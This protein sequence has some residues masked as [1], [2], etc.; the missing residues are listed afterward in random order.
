MGVCIDLISVGTGYTDS[1]FYEHAN[2]KAGPIKICG[3][4]RQTECQFLRTAEP[5]GVCV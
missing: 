3:I 5:C 2:E 1:G 4:S